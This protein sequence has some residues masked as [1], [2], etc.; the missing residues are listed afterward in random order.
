[1]LNLNFWQFPAMAN[2][3]KEIAKMPELPNNPN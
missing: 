2:A 1:M 3:S